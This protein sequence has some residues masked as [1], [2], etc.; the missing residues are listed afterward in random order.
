MNPGE[1]KNRVTFYEYTDNDGPEPGEKKKE[2]LHECWARIDEV[3]LKDLEI[4]K[5]NSTESDLTVTIRDPGKYYRPTNKHYIAI[6]HPD[7]EDNHYN[8]KQVFPDLGNNRF[9]RIVAGIKDGS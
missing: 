4:A 9:I 6:N 1:L 3:W 8:I 7:Y 2:T 5:Y